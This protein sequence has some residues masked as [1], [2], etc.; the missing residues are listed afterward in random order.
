MTKKALI[1]GVTG[2]D[3][4]YLAKL[5][6]SKEYEVWGTCRDIHTSSFHNLQHLGIKNSVNYLIRNHEDFSSVFNALS[7]RDFDDVYCL[8]GQTSVSLSFNVSS[9]TMKSIILGTLN[10]LDSCRL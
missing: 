4:A 3:G 1:C 2:Q 9:H 6:L 5:L 7:T 10:I 8:A